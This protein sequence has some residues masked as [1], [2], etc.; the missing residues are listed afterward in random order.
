MVIRS[1]PLFP[2]PRSFDGAP[3]TGV[4]LRDDGGDG[5]PGAGR[6]GI[7]DTCRRN[8]PGVAAPPAPGAQAKGQIPRGVC[9][10]PASSDSHQLAGGTAFGALQ[11][12]ESVPVLLPLRNPA[13]KDRLGMGNGAVGECWVAF[14]EA[15]IRIH[16]EQPIQV[17]GNRPT[18]DQPAAGG[19]YLLF[20]NGSTPKSG[21]MKRRQR[22]GRDGIRGLML[23]GRITPAPGAAD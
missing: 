9:Q 5:Q 6:P 19:F 17:A 22:P 3:G 2:K 7:F 8:F 13:F 4:V 11:H 1:L 15:G 14:N 20:D 16:S 18:Q 21:P 23:L 10:K 12:P